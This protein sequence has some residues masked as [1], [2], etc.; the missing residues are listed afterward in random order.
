MENDYKT[1]EYRGYNINIKYD[2][3]SRSPR[4]WDN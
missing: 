1:I 4:E 2:S 3:D